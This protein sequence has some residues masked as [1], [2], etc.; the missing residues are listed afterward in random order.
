MQA[1]KWGGARD[2]DYGLGHSATRIGKGVLS[3]LICPEA[4]QPVAQ[5]VNSGT[6]PPWAKFQP[7]YLKL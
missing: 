6:R 3:H 4:E 1:E 5:S 7:C 2:R